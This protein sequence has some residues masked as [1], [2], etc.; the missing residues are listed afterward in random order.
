MATISRASPRAAG[1]AVEQILASSRNTT[2][3]FRAAAIHQ[4][5]GSQASKTDRFED[6]HFI[7]PANGNGK[8]WLHYN[9]TS[10]PTAA[11]IRERNITVTSYY[12]Q[13]AIDRSAEKVR[14]LLLL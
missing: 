13:T 6:E 7:R 14:T 5:D 4:G 8:R 11:S 12:N 10:K 1:A 2:K 3:S 9:Q